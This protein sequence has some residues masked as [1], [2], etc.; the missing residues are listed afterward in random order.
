MNKLNHSWQRWIRAFQSGCIA[1]AFIALTLVGW[2]PMAQATGVYEIPLV[3]PGEGPWV[4]DQGEVLSRATQGGLNSKLENIAKNTDAEIRFVTLRWLDY[5]VTIDDFAQ[6][7]FKQWFPTE[8]DQSHQAVFVLDTKTN[9][10]A[11]LTSDDLKDV[12]PTDTA[13]SISQETALV[14]IRKGSYN[15]GLIDVSDRIEAIVSGEP[16]PGPPVV[17]V[18]EVESTFKSAEET[19]GKT[20]AIVV[21]VLLILAT[22]IPMVT[23]YWYVTQ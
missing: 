3:T 1:I 21:V 6:D 5:E 15:Q 17:E 10:T 14:P 7:L 23:Y 12:L 4:I 9:T 18:R 2:G 19:N 8:A 11:L 20:A 13:K 16:D 22:V